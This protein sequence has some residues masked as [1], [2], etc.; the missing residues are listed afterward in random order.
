MKPTPLQ[1]LEMHRPAIA[2]PGE[3]LG[4]TH[5][6]QHHIKLKPCSNPVYINMYKLLH[7][8]RQLVEALIEDMVYQGVIQ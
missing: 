5:C 2:F 3:P 6:V 7:S 4:I 8:Q 1:V